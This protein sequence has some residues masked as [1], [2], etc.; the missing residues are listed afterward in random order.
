[1]KVN[2]SIP[3]RELA[4]A[5]GKSNKV[6]KEEEHPLPDEARLIAEAIHKILLKE[7]S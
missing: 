5:T 6:I 7:G 1:M 3:R 4:K 2:I